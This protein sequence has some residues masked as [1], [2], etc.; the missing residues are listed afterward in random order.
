MRQSVVR[1][2]V[3]AREAA[4]ILGISTRTVQSLAAKGELPGAAKIGGLWTFDK[5]ALRDWLRSIST[6]DQPAEKAA[7]PRPASDPRA[8]APLQAR[9][10]AKA[11][12]KALQDLRRQGDAGR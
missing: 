12:E 1:E 5:K 4:A 9:N 8:W 10:S 2:R 11:C 3:R 7:R 6:P